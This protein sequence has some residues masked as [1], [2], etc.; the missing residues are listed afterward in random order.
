MSAT[1]YVWVGG[2]VIELGA[3][4]QAEKYKRCFIYWL[5]IWGAKR[6]VQVVNYQW[7]YRPK[8]AMP[9]EFLLA[10]LIMGVQT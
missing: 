4:D 8:S 5:D 1:Y 7:G 2:K 10:L 6:W 3:R 9:K